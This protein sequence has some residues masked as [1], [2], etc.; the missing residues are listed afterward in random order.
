MPIDRWMDKEDV[1]YICNAILLSNKKRMKDA[2]C[3]IMDTPKDYHVKWNSQ[4]EKDK[5]YVLSFICETKIWHKWIYQW[6]RNRLT[7]TKYRLCQGGVGCEGMNW[8]LGIIRC[9]L[10]YIEWINNKVLLYSRGNYIQYLII[11]HNGK[12]YEKE[13]ICVYSFAV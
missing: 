12:E 5:H 8:E 10:L 11:N 6:N 13:Y 7:D 1:V 2:I 9:K 3:N 4:K